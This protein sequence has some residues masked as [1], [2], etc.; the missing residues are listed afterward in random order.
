MSNAISS[1]TLFHFTDCAEKLIS[2][3]TN[4]FK[5]KFCLEDDVLFMNDGKAE[6]DTEIAIPMVC[7]CD[8]LLSEVRSHLQFYG[9]YGIGMTKAWGK[10]RGINPVFY[11]NCDSSAYAY[12]SKLYKFIFSDDV[13]NAAIK[14]TLPTTIDSLEFMSFLKLYEGRMWRNDKYVIKRFYD[15]R[16]WRYVPHLLQAGFKFDDG[17]YRL[18]KT[19]YLNSILKAQADSVI[20]QRITLK[21][22][23]TDIKYIIVS[24]ENEISAIISAI[25]Q[26][27]GKYDRETVK[28]L[29]SRVISTEQIIEDF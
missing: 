8:L 18:S 12:L 21:F 24:K 6:N 11:I 28:I 5:P 10:K 20:A 16:E 7:F 4:E 22:E 26:I 14:T 3:L 9:S 1:N 19:E 29:A 23:P 25:E 17:H 2:I 15:E 13:T 27:K